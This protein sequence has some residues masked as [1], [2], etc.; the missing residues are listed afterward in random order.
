MEAE[1]PA[2]L[3]GSVSLLQLHASVG[4]DGN[5]IRGLQIHPDGIHLIY[6]MGNKVTIKN[7]NTNEQ[8]F[9]AGHTNTISA[10][11]VSRS[12]KYVASGQINHIG[13]KASVILW[14]FYK[15]VALIKH[16]GHKVRVE[17]V[18]FSRR[19][20]YLLSLGGRDCGSV[21]VWDINKNKLICG[22]EAT[23]GSQGDAT[24]L[25]TMNCRGPCF[26]TAGEGNL[27]VWKIDAEARSVIGIDVSLSK[28][29]RK[30][31]CMDVNDR[32]EIC[33]CGTSTGDMLKL[34]LNFHHDVEILEPVKRPMMVGCFTKISKKKLQPGTVELYSMG[35]RSIILMNTGEIIIGAGDGTIDVV[36]E[37]PPK[38]DKRITSIAFK[39]PS[40]PALK[41]IKT[42]NVKHAV[43][44]LVLKDKGTCILAG[45]LNCEVFSIDMKT[46]ETKLIITCHTSTI[47]DTAFPYKFSDI[48]A[49]ASKDS[50]RLWSM[51]TMDELLRIMVPNFSCSKVVFA[52]D[53]RSILTAWNDGVIRAFTPLTGRL[54]Y[55]ILNAHN[56]GVSA[57]D[58][59]HNGK[60]IISGGCEGQVRIWDIK[61]TSQ[62]LVCTLKE[63]TGPV[64]AIHINRTDDEAVSASTDGTCIIWDILRQIRKQILF[65]NTLFMTVHYYPSSVQILTGGSDRKLCY[66]EVLDGSLVREIEGSTSGSIN[67]LDISAD[68]QFFVTGANDQIVKMW[69]YQEGITTHIGLG[70]CSVITAVCISPDCN[71]V[72][73]TGGAGEIFVWKIPESLKEKPSVVNEV[74]DHDLN[75]GGDANVGNSKEENIQHL[76][77]SRSDASGSKKGKKCCRPCRPCN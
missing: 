62:N 48:F 22:A 20:E 27:M 16:E 65:E 2:E 59:S 37:E 3:D 25:Y 66:W 76:E 77:S 7:T 5:T 75:A 12:G 70:H 15:H 32:D 46:F 18:A 67:S 34:R 24:V 53:G 45:T 39:L 60:F 10:I 52:H 73:T 42:T 49:T 56:K 64:S 31:L 17:A 8:F 71:Y 44:T 1:C 50:V 54:I 6:P 11:D 58:I 41:V 21:V 38:I 28:L 51:K 43:T 4:F 33:L 35:I 55:A 47:F 26:M 40:N 23:K 9:L 68:G 61:P 74:N 19:D 36:L 29:K 72:I 13:F 57:M 69:K 63:H 14:D 30:V